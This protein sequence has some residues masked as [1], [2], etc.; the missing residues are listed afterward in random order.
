MNINIPENTKA[1]LDLYATEGV[2]T[3]GFLYKVLTDDLFGEICKADDFNQR[4]IVNICKY[5]YNELPQGCW[6]D[7][8]K[9]ANW[10]EYK[11]NENDNK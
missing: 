5:V 2:P 4:V 11:K 6:G 1:S 3:E 9:V 8:E 10:I 7:E